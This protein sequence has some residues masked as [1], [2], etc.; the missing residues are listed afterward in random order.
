VAIPLT[1]ILVR[2]LWIFPATYLLP[3]P[4]PPWQ[5]T[6]MVAWTGMR[7]AVSLAAALAIPLT[8]DLG[9]PFP[10]RPLIVFLA[11][12]V[13]LAT[14]VVQGLSLPLV[15]RALGLT[16]DGSAAHEEEA[17]ARVAAAEAALARL[18][19]LEPEGWARES[20]VDRLRGTYEF[21]KRRF[22]ERLDPEADGAHEE[23]SLAYQ[24]LRSELLAAE[25]GALLGL[26]NQGA[27]STETWVRLERDLD[28]EHSRLD[29]PAIDR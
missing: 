22:A 21:R 16:D 14:L 11:F 18:A 2:F 17:N 7:G 13:I 26:R 25:R 15:V 8:T 28:L 9:E 19:E 27:I 23:R 29:A 20:T 1:V 3:G 24:R 6:A 12:S 4:G 5:W 10:Q